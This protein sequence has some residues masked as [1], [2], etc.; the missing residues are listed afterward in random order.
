MPLVRAHSLLSIKE[1]TL[2]RNPMSVRSVKRLSGLVLTS[3]D[4]RGFILERS[5]MNVRFVGKPTLRAHSSSVITGFTRG[6]KPIN[7][8]TV[9]R[10]SAMIHNLFSIKTCTGDKNTQGVYEDSRRSES[11]PLKSLWTEE[12]RNSLLVDLSLLI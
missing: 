10:A 12:C 1:S 2:V 7:T 6:R 4:T 3:L 5:P 9:Q 8:R 11:L